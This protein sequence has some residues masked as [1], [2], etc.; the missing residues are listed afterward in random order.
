MIS[1]FSEKHN[2]VALSSAETEY[3]TE[4][5]DRCES[6]WLRKLLTDLFVH[7]LEPMVIYFDN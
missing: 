2:F 3:M 7:E 6:I 1:L 5:K 4:S